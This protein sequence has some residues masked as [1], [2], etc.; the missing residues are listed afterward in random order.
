MTVDSLELQISAEAKKANDAIDSIIRNLGNLT[1]AL[2]ID[3]SGISNIG[4]TLDFSKITDSAKVMSETV[5]KAG[6]T[7]AQSMKPVQEEVKKT[8]KSVEQV[9][10]E[11]SNKNKDLGKGFAMQGSL[12]QVRKESQKIF[13][14]WEKAK[15]DLQRISLGE[16]IDPSKL[17]KAVVKV[18][19]LGNK[20]QSLQDRISESNK[21]AQE[22]FSNQAR[23]SDGLEKEI[24]SAGE[25]LKAL[26]SSA[27]KVGEIK[28]I[29]DAKNAVQEY[30]ERLKNLI[31]QKKDLETL[32]AVNGEPY[33]QLIKDIELYQS[34]IKDISKEFDIKV[35]TDGVN[36]AREKIE[37]LYQMFEDSGKDLVF[38]GNAEQLDQEIQKVKSELDDLYK[39]RDK[40]IE[41]GKID[42]EPFKTL[43]RDIENAINRLKVLEDARPE[44]LNRTLE[45]NAEK[46]RN[47]ANQLKQFEAKL[48]QLRVPPVQE[49][50]IEKLQNAL[51]KTEADIEKLQTKLENGLILGKI[52][53]DID[54]SSYRSLREQIALTEKE[55]EALRQ[56]IE[57]VG[58]A[59]GFEKLKKSLTDLSEMIKKENKSVSS[60]YST[61]KRLNSSINSVLAKIG[62]F[63]KSMFSLGEAAKSSGKGFNLNLKTILKYG[64][65]IRSVYVLVNKLRNAIKEGMKNL[66][67]YSDETN[68]SI[69]ALASS[70]ATLKNASAAAISPL[71]NAIA[72]ALNQIIQLFIRATNA[73]N[74]FFAA[75]TGR[76]TWIKAKD[77][78]VDYADSISKA[79]DSAKGALQPFDKL[80][81]LTTQKA[82]GGGVNAEDMFETLPIAD[83][84]KELADKIKDILSKLFAPLKEAWNRQ[85]KFV[86]KA[87]KYALDEV[88]KLIKDIGR[89]FLK[90]W[91]Q[92]KTIK[93][94][95]DILKII[96]YIGLTI[97]K[98]A[99]KFREAWNENETGLRI[100]ENIRDIIGV[101]VTKIREMAAL[102][103]LWAMSL[104]FSPLLTKIEE[105]T[106]SL[107]PV[108]E[109]LAGIIRDFYAE[110]L[111]PLAKW[112]L[113]EGIPKLLD[114]FIKFNEKVDW[115]ALRDNLAEFWKHLEPFAETV[116]EGLIIFIERVSGLVADFLNS[117]TFVNFLH[118][119]EDWMDSVTPEDVADAITKLAEALIALKIAVLGFMAIKAVTGIF[120]T[121]T[122][123]FS[124]IGTLGKIVVSGSKL[125]AGGI[126]SILSAIGSI[127]AVL[128]MV[129]A[130]VVGWKIGEWINKNLLGVDTPSFFEMMDGIKSSFQDGSWKDALKLWGD[131]IYDAFVTLGE[132]E[133]EKFNEIKQNIAEKWESI[134]SD[135]A[136]KWEEIKGNLS[137][138]W[139]SIKGDAS[140]KFGDIKTDVIKAWDDLKAK[141]TEKWESIKTTVRNAIEKLKGF[142]KF[143]WSLPKIKLPHFKISGKFS[144]TP[145]SVPSIGVD[146]YAKGGIFDQAQV[147]GVGEA[148]REAVLPLTDSK[149]MKMIADGIMSQYQGTGTAEASGYQLNG[150]GD[151]ELKKLLRKNNELLEAIL[152]KPTLTDKDIFDSVGKQY[153]EKARRNGYS[154]DPVFS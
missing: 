44:A 106:K 130:A 16:N 120:I 101:V 61:F 38:S 79:S 14:D 47:A 50:N 37:K 81:N 12:E 41:L 147:I 103:Y 56:K 135:T 88:W 65:G 76:G 108:F 72:P 82:A 17:E 70:I 118:A 19:E 34:K 3:T 75:L 35:K 24:T 1:G 9:I 85:G 148:G 7:M 98:L 117:E 134:K 154:R 2:K 45:E 99:E 128:A 109:N 95:E 150:Q 149:A 113:E 63:S 36:E 122:T 84:F 119:I 21:Q 31:A 13:N 144:L 86:M 52:T 62:K 125:I 58:E 6:A 89:D 131:D 29:E 55:A 92:E 145:P 97:G 124:S 32:G 141:T 115:Q 59:N 43:I 71:L 5:G 87:W 152:E 78:I 4:K 116:G 153:G 126:G 139:E 74:Q 51:K 127:P 123:F 142:L 30:G 60:L 27:S 48:K 114:V 64:F 42:T 46:A 22:F 136:T 83:K 93:I 80:N 10:S 90:V 67:Q 91:Q 18:V 129:A 104:D 146:W 133:E 40:Y 20:Y 143:E 132:R 94:F 96:G 26:A 66:V 73:V 111:L 49:E 102:T 25:E 110:V 54:D 39:K 8:A 33:K 28:G 138:K 69:S 77:Q 151:P 121:L 105:W 137:E 107:I 57:E 53:E 140:T 11:I 23:Q 68:Q 112:T 15:V 100:L